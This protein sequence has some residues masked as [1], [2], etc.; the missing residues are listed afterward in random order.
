VLR[1]EKVKEKIGIFE[2]WLQSW[3]NGLRWMQTRNPE[4]KYEILSSK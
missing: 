1:D 3:L 4:G 2:A